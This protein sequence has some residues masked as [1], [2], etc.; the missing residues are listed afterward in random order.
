MRVRA[1]NNG[2]ASHGVEPSIKGLDIASFK[3]NHNPA[4]VYVTSLGALFKGDCLKI[5]PSFPT[6]CVD[7]V[8]ADPPFNIGKDY[9][10]GVNDRLTD[11]EYIQWCHRWIDGCIR[12][13]RPG[14]S[15]FLYNIP[16]WNIRLANFLLDR[17]MHFCDWIV[18]DIKLGLPIPGRLYPSHYS[19]LY[20]SK[21]KDKTFHNIR[22]PITACR[23][24]GGDVKDYGGHRRSLNPRGLNLTDVWND[25]PPVRHWKFKSKKRKANALSTKLLDRIVEMS[26]EPLDVVLDPFGGSGTTYAV[27]EKKGRRWIGIEVESTDVI[28]ERLEKNE[29]RDYKN[30]DFV[31][32][33]RR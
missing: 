1:R 19:L 24:C 16:K 2:N 5:L 32:S 9:G 8:F 21:G 30:E 27:C 26:T 4:P 22:T 7:T 25:I 6:A 20:F 12:V 23:H 29:L 15:F 31:E 13:L 33:S 28:I 11:D 17:E 14:G 3:L 18:V 10:E